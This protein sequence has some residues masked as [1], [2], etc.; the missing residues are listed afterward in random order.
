MSLS[1]SHYGLPASPANRSTGM[2]FA[3]QED[4]AS[5]G[6]NAT[7]NSLP[8]RRLHCAPTAPSSPKPQ[9]CSGMEV[10]TPENPVTTKLEPSPKKNLEI[11]GIVRR[12][13]RN[14]ENPR[15]STSN[16]IVH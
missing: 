11:H 15:I 9:N 12:E 3:R 16:G 4:S 2:R 8:N 10:N 13:N 1:L 5:A 14:K 7:R 6:M